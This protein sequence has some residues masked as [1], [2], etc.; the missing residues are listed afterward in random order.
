MW[1]IA[2]R[3]ASCT[4]CVYTFMVWISPGQRRWA[5]LLAN[6]LRHPRDRRPLTDIRNVFRGPAFD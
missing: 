2:S 4:A 5:A 1:L 3:W 6:K